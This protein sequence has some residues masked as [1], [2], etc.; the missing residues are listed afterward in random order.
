MS[1]TNCIGERLTIVLGLFLIALAGYCGIKDC[2][3]EDLSIGRLGPA[4]EPLPTTNGQGHSRLLPFTP[5]LQF[6]ATTP[7]H[8]GDR[9]VLLPA[10]RWQMSTGEAAGYQLVLEDTER[11]FVVQFERQQIYNPTLI[12]RKDGALMMYTRFE[13]RN[14]IGRWKTCPTTSLYQTQVCPAPDLRMVSF[15]A[16]CRLQPSTFRCM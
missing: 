3:N 6:G 1:I 11:T 13:G 15:V 8:S 4:L 16:S 9:H 2:G 12:I 5:S 7:A 10:T 14:S